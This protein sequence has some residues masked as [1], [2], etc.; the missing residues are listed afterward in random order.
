[1]GNPFVAVVQYSSL[2]EGAPKDEMDVL[3]QAGAVSLALSKRAFSTSPGR[4]ASRS[5]RSSGAS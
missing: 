5:P 1:M 3:Q 4:T 2:P